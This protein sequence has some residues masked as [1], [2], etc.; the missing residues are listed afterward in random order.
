M[1]TDGRTDGGRISTKPISSD[2]TP[3]KEQR[4][5]GE[6][7]GQRSLGKVVGDKG[8]LRWPMQAHNYATWKSRTSQSSVLWPSR[9]GEDPRLTIE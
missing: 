1:R 2:L 4:G 9:D 3:A 7:L 8:V 6:Q 5:G